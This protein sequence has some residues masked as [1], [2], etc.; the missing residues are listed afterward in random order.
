MQVVNI[1]ASFPSYVSAMGKDVLTAKA[2]PLTISLPQYSA[3]KETEAQESFMS[4]F[5]MII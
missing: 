4:Q 2:A 1:Y 3:S 5:R